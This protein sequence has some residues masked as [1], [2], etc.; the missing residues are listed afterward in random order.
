MLYE[1]DY[2]SPKNK[3]EL[4]EIIA[5]KNGECKI[6]AGGTDLLVDIRNGIIK[7]KFV[8]DI[9]TVKDFPKIT[10]SEKEG[11]IIGPT[12][13][14]FDII[15]NKLIQEKFPALVLTAKELG[16]TQIR[17]RATIIGNICNASPCADMSLSLLCL[18]ASVDIISKEGTRRVKIKEFFTGV[19]KTVLNKGEVVEKIIIPAVMANAKAGFKKLKRIKGHD[20]SL[21][22]VCLVKKGKIMRVAV[23]SAAPTSVVSDDIDS[24]SDFPT[25]WSKIEKLIN[26]ID[27]IR[28]SK[29]Y[30]IFMVKVYLERLLKEVK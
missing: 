4:L 25:V 6:L 22:S 11:L 20:L 5:E 10:Y 2:I 23:G 14:C 24:N 29:D 17:N 30:R 3:N 16:S 19:K 15:E 26:P 9:K 12:I 8:V 21:V 27:D 18:D 13:T 7:P 28:C 1:F